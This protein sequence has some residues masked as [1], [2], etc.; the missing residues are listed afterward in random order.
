MKGF[1]KYEYSKQEEGS[2]YISVEEKYRWFWKRPYLITQLTAAGLREIIASANSFSPVSLNTPG[3]LSRRTA[4][5]L[6][7]AL[8]DTYREAVC[9]SYMRGLL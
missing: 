7:P 9:V 6:N 3:T 2:G 1:K 4:I 8:R 5:P